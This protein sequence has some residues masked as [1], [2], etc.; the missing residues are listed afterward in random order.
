MT[1]LDRAGVIHHASGA[2]DFVDRTGTR[3]T[4]S[5]IARLEFSERLIS[6]LP[7]P[8]RRRGWLLFESEEGERRRYSPIPEN[9]RELSSLKLQECLGSAAVATSLERRRREDQEPR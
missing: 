3:W 7:H 4:V 6:L 9:W 1:R 2:L 8:E 5:E